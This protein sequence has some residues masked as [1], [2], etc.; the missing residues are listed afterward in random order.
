MKSSQSEI[1]EGYKQTEVGVI[2]EDW[3]VKELCQIV[4]SKRPISYGI[5]QTGKQVSNGVRCIRVLDIENGQVNKN[6]L[7]T[8]SKEISNLYR[9]TILKEGDLVIALRGKIGE[10]ALI[11]KDLADSNL[12]RGLAL[13]SL[14][15]ESH[16]R[17]LYHQLSSASSKLIFE[18]NLNGSALQEIS[19]G[20]LRK[21]TVA[22][23]PLPEQHAIAEVLSDTDA[24]MTSLDQ[25]IAKK[26]NIKQG[27]MQVLLTGKKRLAGFSSEW[28]EKELNRVATFVNG[29]AYS[30]SEW[31]TSGT[32]V[33]RLQNLTGSG[34]AYYYSNLNL[35]QHQYCNKGDLL[36]MWS[37]SF[38]PYIWQ[39]EKA[40]YHY[41]IWKI[42]CDESQLDRLYLFYQLDDLTN[43]LKRKASSGGTMLH[44]TKETMESVRILLP[45]LP[46]QQA[47]AEVL[48]DMDAEIEALEK[49]RDKYKAIKQ[50]MM[51][52]LLTGKTRLV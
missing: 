30:L 21:I 15:K 23:P 49:K 42:E 48:S 28:E 2:P 10:L 44:V 11:D 27:A 6:N 41:H 34:E 38:G 5:V 13:I 20:G 3:E 14:T 37:A 24:L 39:G 9:R 47:I 17:F 26:R 45:S 50:G 51:Q 52:E 1:R 18:K 40:I 8:T 19:I 32:P 43:H 36:Y 46:E 16:N 12:T 29:R 22:L 4:E 7:I 35:P 31:E 33:I 25:L